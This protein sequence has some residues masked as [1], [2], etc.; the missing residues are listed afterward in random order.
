MKIYE[1]LDKKQSEPEYLKLQKFLAGK[2]LQTLNGA[3]RGEILSMPKVKPELCR[4]KGVK[5]AENTATWIGHSTVFCSHGAVNYITD[6][7]FSRRASP[8]GF[9]GPLRYTP[10]ALNISQLPP[11]NFVLITHNHYDHLD[12]ASVMQ[13]S[14]A[15]DPLFIVPEGLGGWFVKNGMTNVREIS[16]W[17]SADIDGMTVTSVPAQH[18]SARTLWDRNHSHW[19]GW[20]VRGKRSF[21]YSGD[22]G[23]CGVFG[24]ISKRLGA[25]D[26][27]VLPIG[28]Y[29]PAWMMQRHHLNPEEAVAAYRELGAGKLLAVHWGAFD[30]TYERYDEPP[31]RLKKEADRLGLGAE[32]ICIPRIGQTILW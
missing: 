24:E 19:C 21:Y 3:G 9:M 13:I 28:A 20:V 31:L 8:F 14:R 4:E 1:N 26:L 27:A 2:L 12:R 6:P 30:L 17:E 11:M 29:E 15:H 25:P 32:C 16:W 5:M 10:P 23:Y 7:M 18:F 22:T